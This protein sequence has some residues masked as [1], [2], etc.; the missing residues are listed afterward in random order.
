MLLLWV[1][2]SRDRDGCFYHEIN[3]SP[4]ALLFDPFVILSPC[5]RIRRPARLSK[6]DVGGHFETRHTWI[7]SRGW[8]SGRNPISRPSFSTKSNSTWQFNIHSCSSI[9][10]ILGVYTEQA[11]CSSVKCQLSEFKETAVLPNTRGVW[12]V[13]LRTRTGWQ[14]FSLESLNFPSSW[15]SNSEHPRST[16]IKATAISAFLMS[17]LRFLAR[18]EVT[19][20]LEVYILNKLACA[21]NGGIHPEKL[22][23]FYLS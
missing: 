6:E 11:T 20:C 7:W 14:S 9:K 19:N 17:N 16:R 21:A 18:L 23:S 22:N 3:K 13:G 15:M 5:H 4:R 2:I 1:S 12:S 10:P 8:E